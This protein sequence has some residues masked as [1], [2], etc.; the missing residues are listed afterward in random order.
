[1]KLF[2][3]CRDCKHAWWL[4]YH[5]M[6]ISQHIKSF[7]M[8]FLIKSINSLLL[9]LHLQIDLIATLFINS[10]NIWNWQLE[11]NSFRWFQH[12]GESFVK[13]PVLG[14]V[15][16]LTLAVSPF[17]IAFATVWAVYRRLS[18]AWI[19]QDI[20]VRWTFIPS[21]LAFSDNYNKSEWLHYSV[22]M[23]DHSPLQVLQKVK[24]C[25]PHFFWKINVV[26]L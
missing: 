18:Y 21:L 7:N 6:Y 11:Q 17:C 22:K 26:K 24:V 12:A 1:M 15:S 14:A 19:G 8:A 25:L 5:G 2:Y 20:L 13:V 23:W 4:C 3:A 9:E 10:S 16:H